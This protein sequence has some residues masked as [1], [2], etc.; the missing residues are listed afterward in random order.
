MA[1]YKYSELP[2]SFKLVKNVSK[3]SFEF[4]RKSKELYKLLETFIGK[5]EMQPNT[6]GIHFNGVGVEATDTMKMVILA[7]TKLED[8]GIY[9]ASG[10]KIDATFPDY[11]SV[12]PTDIKHK[13]VIDVLK[14]KTFC[15]TVLS[16]QMP[17]EITNQIIFPITNKFPS[18]ISA[19]AFNGW[20]LIETLELWLRLGHSVIEFHLSEP[21]KPVLMLPVGGKPVINDTVLLMPVIVDRAGDSD[22]KGFIS[23]CDLDYN[24]ELEGIYDL[25]KNK[26]IQGDG[27]HDVRTDITTANMRPQGNVTLAQLQLI[28]K[29]I[30]KKTFL[31]VLAYV[32]VQKDNLVLTDLEFSYRFK[33]CGLKDGLY[34]PVKGGLLHCPEENPNDFP[35]IPDVNPDKE[36]KNICIVNGPNFQK[37]F[38]KAQACTT[39]DDL[40][41][42]L[43]G[44]YM[45]TT[46]NEIIIQAT[47][48][49]TA[50]R[51]IM[52]GE[53]AKEGKHI[54]GCAE[55]T[56]V[57]LTEYPNYPFTIS[58]NSTNTKIAC[59]HYEIV[60]RNVEGRFPDV[61]TVA[62]KSY[63]K[64]ITI[65]SADIRKMK[66]ELNKVKKDY[67]S[68][69]LK[70]QGANRFQVYVY[71]VKTNAKGADKKYLYDITGTV[72]TVKQ[73]ATDNAFY[74]AQNISSEGDAAIEFGIQPINSIAK[75]VTGSSVD[76]YTASG[77]AVYMMLETGDKEATPVTL[78][79]KNDIGKIEPAARPGIKKEKT[80]SMITIQNYTE[81]AAKV[82]FHKLSAA[83][84]EGNKFVGEY[85]DLYEDDESIKETI[86]L[87]LKQLNEAVEKQFVKEHFI[88][89]KIDSGE[90]KP[91][92][93][94]Y[95]LLTKEEVI[96][97]RDRIEALETLSKEDTERMRDLTKY[98]YS[99]F[100]VLLKDLGEPEPEVTTA[101]VKD[102]SCQILDTTGKPDI[103]PAAI[104]K[105]ENCA[106]N[107]PQ[108][109]T[110]VQ[111]NGKYTPEREAKHR[112]IIGEIKAAKP[113]VNQRQPVAIL[114]GGPPGAGKTTWIK[115][116]LSWIVS[117]NVYHI[118][119]D[120]VRAKLPEYVG[121]NATQTH[122]ETKD[123]VNQLIDEIGN[124]CEYDLVYDGTMNKANSYEPLVNK[125]RGL[126]YKIFI[127]YISVPK[128]VSEKRVLERYREHGRYVPQIVI[129]EVYKNGLVAFD[130]LTKEADGFIRVDGMNGKIVDKG[131]MEIPK[132]ERYEKPGKADCAEKKKVEPCHDC[133]KPHRETKEEGTARNANAEQFIK[134]LEAQPDK[135]KKMSEAH[136][137]ELGLKFHKTYR[138]A[139]AQ[140]R[141]ASHD[142]V[143]RLSPTPENLIRWMKHPG[144]FD[145]IGVDSFARIDATADYKREI[146]KQKFWHNLYGIKI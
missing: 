62:A 118:D 36:F 13:F 41:P 29:L 25:S 60:S 74:I 7:N 76:F 107:L 77:K 119:A 116:H 122:L 44:V 30:N 117:D 51:G 6:Q 81:T 54:F 133:S 35:R 91:K 115:K 9:H 93:K 46:S 146:S 137:I 67:F 90:K 130:K 28:K 140:S 101:A 31:P 142:S 10:K 71:R 21:N 84:Q 19:I 87:Y 55:K 138:T 14:L 88:I 94:A 139:A 127:I 43:T 34:L 26:V 83:L 98:C 123:I 113:C 103:T 48:G 22:V 23:A 85:G 72:E 59:E 89:G 40:R 45:E 65:S 134:D 69:G 27:E 57:V 39:K 114:T 58:G 33:N 66:V 49:H 47:D 50:Y 5:D 92:L 61:Q 141:D 12:I 37:Q 86:D 68:I 96:S 110:T 136:I 126:G 95:Y 4:S 78:P 63:D 111:V 131:G 97:E 100:K 1:K 64:K 18:D 17:N 120:E 15:E 20:F 32:K 125:L 8:E 75:G 128:E 53:L 144:S 108:T 135:L 70:P 2:D 132:K 105:F 38:Q 79:T 82:H 11:K 112:E 124:P 52:S 24:R 121:W 73:S 102:D 106:E 143:K 16:A 99:K 145:L 104:K 42:V 129:D 80:T 109:K 3:L 56:N